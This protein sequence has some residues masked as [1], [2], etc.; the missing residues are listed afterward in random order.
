MYVCVFTYQ[1]LIDHHF[2][3]KKKRIRNQTHPWLDSTVLKLMRT[4]DQAHKRAKT[5]RLSSDWNEYKLLRNKVTAMHRKAR[6]HYFRNKLEENR[7][8]P[9]AFWDTQI[10]IQIFQIQ[11]SDF[12]LLCTIYNTYNINSIEE[13]T[14]LKERKNITNTS[15]K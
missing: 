13:I 6:K 11:I 5:Y 10:Q 12:L 14:S 15:P 1:S 4:R 9:K 3:L 7:G 8:Q 2:P